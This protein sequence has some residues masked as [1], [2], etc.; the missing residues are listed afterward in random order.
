M[1]STGIHRKKTKS[2]LGKEN[3]Y[4]SKRLQDLT[5][6]TIR[7]GT[8][9]IPSGLHSVALLPAT[10]L[11]TEGNWAGLIFAK[12]SGT[13]LGTGKK[14]NW[15]I[16]DWCVP[17]N[18]PRNYCGTNFD[19][20]SLHLWPTLLGAWERLDPWHWTTNVQNA[21]GSILYLRNLTA[22]KLNKIL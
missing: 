21:A 7:M 10:R 19:S 3:L 15:P 5:R 16:A 4:F 6:A 18:D 1:W 12:T 20:S 11:A 2:T 17:S 13:L 8:D 22:L 14:K 9:Q